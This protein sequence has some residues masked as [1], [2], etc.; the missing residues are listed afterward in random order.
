VTTTRDRLLAA[1][2]ECFR[3]RGYNGTSVK[4]VTEAAGAPVGSLYHFFPGGKDELAEAALLASGDAY[5]QLFV[6]FA[7]AAAGPA[8]L[9]TDF[10]DGAADVL[11]QTDYVDPCPIGTVAREVA[12]T[13]ERLRVATASVF[14]SWVDA[15]AARF[16]DAGI[17]SA[18]AE[19]LASTLV[20]ALEGGFVL[21]RAARDAE[22]LRAIGR[23][24]RVLVHQALARV[25]AVTVA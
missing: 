7:D 9:V 17:A 14:A 23:E 24:M 1:T 22:P 10:F 11:E 5:R 12:S 21:A 19:A 2:N 6:M 13:N 4:H 18:D 20:A 3:R 25:P 8:E 16:V 15:A